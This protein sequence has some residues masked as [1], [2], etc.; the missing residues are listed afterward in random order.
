MVKGRRGPPKKRGPKPK[1]KKF[2]PK[3]KNTNANPIGRPTAFDENLINKLE[4]A[5]SIGCSDREACLYAGIS[6]TALYNHQKRHPEFVER[7][8]LLKSNPILKA[9]TS[10]FTHLGT[11]PRLALK[12]LE[13]KRKKEFSIRSEVTG[14]G[15]TDLFTKRVQKMTDQELAEEFAKSIAA[16]KHLKEL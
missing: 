16:I 11:D 12:F 5:F 2:G 3:P 14:A 15:G 7:K 8:K 6:G 10:V 13:R 1:P 9:R 4:K